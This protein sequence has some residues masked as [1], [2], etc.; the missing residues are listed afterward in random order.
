M[1]ALVLFGRLIAPFAIDC[2]VKISAAAIAALLAACFLGRRQPASSFGFILASFGLAA[3][4]IFGRGLVWS[5][6]DPGPFP[7]FSR[8]HVPAILPS[9]QVPSAA[10]ARTGIPELTAKYGSIFQIRIARPPQAGVQPA[11]KPAGVAESLW[12]PALGFVWLAGFLA[13]SASHLMGIQK[14]RSLL[15]SSRPCMDRKLLHAAETVRERLAVRRAELLV[16][17]ASQVAF[18][19][20]FAHSRIVLPPEAAEWPE[21]RLTSTLLHEYM[22]VKRLDV[23]VAEGLRLLASLAWFSP[24]P[25]L[26]FSLALQL[27]EQACDAAVLRAGIPRAAYATDLLDAAW[28]LAQAALPPP[29][30]AI[31]GGSHL[32]CRIRAILEDPAAAPLWDRILRGAACTLLL[33]AALAGVELAGPIWSVP[34]VSDREARA[35]GSGEW[36]AA[37]DPRQGGMPTQG[38]FSFS[39]E[40]EF[41]RVRLR[42]RGQLRDI[43]V[44][45]LAIPSLIPLSV[46]ARMIVPFGELMDGQTRKPFFNPGWSICDDRQVPVVA[47]APGRVVV[48]GIDT[49]FGTVIEVEHGDGLETRYGLGR[50]GISCVEVGEWV[51]AGMPLGTFAASSPY[52]PPVLN[53][54]VLVKVSGEQVALDPAPFMLTLAVNRVAP[55]S[56]SVVNAAIRLEDRSELQRLLAQG[57]ALNHPSTDGTLPLEWALF[58]ENLAI[59]KD[60]VAAGA[61]PQ[62]TTWDVHPAHIALRGPTVAELARNSA[63]PA[64]AALLAPER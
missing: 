3:V 64:L 31:S 29:A 43:R 58:T 13:L 22:H 63:N 5:D 26:A 24:F 23:P 15:K 18:V 1:D 49:R 52:H 46:R 33:A 17:P 35:R 2:V 32:E 40:G 4:L 42:Y 51:T 38:A 9:E 14:V 47:S 6:S 25:W 34:D 57:V 16:S 30:A 55:L 8:A 27:R 36:I 60:L 28:A 41:A 50:H 21:P 37:A 20:G 11:T 45:P 7:A 19:A 39:Q 48:A 10:P 54:S 61:D 44:F 12:I 62:T 59:A 56:A 53:F